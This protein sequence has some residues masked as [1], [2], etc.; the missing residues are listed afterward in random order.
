MEQEDN[1]KDGRTA[2]VDDLSEKLRAVKLDIIDAQQQMSVGTMANR[3]AA[4]GELAMLESRQKNLCDS[5]QHAEKHHA[6]DWSAIRTGLQQDVDAI[7]ESFIN[8]LH[9]YNQ[10]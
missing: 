3:V 9:K 10:R 7:Q 4:A 2:Y 6:E 1:T 8:W 5:I